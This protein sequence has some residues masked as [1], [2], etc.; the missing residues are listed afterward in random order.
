LQSSRQIIKDAVD[1]FPGALVAFFAVVGLI[2][3]AIS[4]VFYS[5]A[6]S[7]VS[8]GMLYWAGLSALVLLSAA[9]LVV[10]IYS[11]FKHSRIK[12]KSEEVEEFA[13]PTKK[14]E[15]LREAREALLKAQK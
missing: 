3:T 12:S 7:A 1:L 9:I 14:Y 15:T 5:A 4:V 6:S 10:V 13:D 11:F 2:T 8:S